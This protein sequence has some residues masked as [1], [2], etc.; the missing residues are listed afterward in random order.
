MRTRI[1]LITLAAAASMVAGGFQQAQ[2]LTSCSSDPRCRDL[3]RELET[4][5]PDIIPWDYFWKIDRTVGHADD[6]I[7][8]NPE[9]ALRPILKMIDRT[10]PVPQRD[11]GSPINCSAKCPVP[12]P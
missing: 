5:A 1:L 10:I 7:G 3:A 11:V 8:V 9:G 12:R 2:G 6:G 4:T